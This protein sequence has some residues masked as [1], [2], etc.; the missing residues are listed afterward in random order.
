MRGA[1]FVQ[2]L[3]AGQ[4]PLTLPYR[5]VLLFAAGEVLAREKAADAQLKME[6]GKE[7]LRR[8]KV[9]QGAHK[10]RPFV[11][12]GG[13]DTRQQL[14]GPDRTGLY[15]AGIWLRSGTRH[16]LSMTELIIDDFKL[17]LDVRRSIL[18]AEPGSLQ[19]L[20]NCH[21]NPGGEIEKR[22]AIP[23]VTALPPGQTFG[24]IGTDGQLHV[25]GFAAPMAI[26]PGASPFPI[27]YHQLEW[28]NRP[29]QRIV[30]I[31]VFQGQ[32]LVC[33]YNSD[34]T[35]S[36]WWNGVPVYDAVS[37]G[38]GSYV[39]VW[40]QKM[41]RVSGPY[42]AFAGIGNPAITDPDDT[43][44]AGAGF[45]DLTSIDSESD[46]LQGLELYYKQMAAF[47]RT[48][49]QIWNLDPDPASNSIDQVLRIGTVSPRSVKQFGTGD[50]LF[51]SDSGI[52]SLKAINASMAA[53]VNDVG[54]PID[55]LM[56]DLIRTQYGAVTQAVAEVAPMSGRYWLAIGNTIFVLSYFPAAKISAWS[57]YSLPFAPEFLTTCVNR[58][59]ARAGDELYMYG[60]A[61]GITYDNSLATVVT[62][63]MSADTPTTWKKPISIDLMCQGLW[64]LQAGMLANSPGARELVG[65]FDGQTYSLQSI[66]Y[67]GYG[68]HI[69]L[70]LTTTDP[71]PA[72]LGS[73]TVNFLKADVK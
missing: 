21:I 42:L 56:I 66:P 9:R 23:A 55:K 38:P 54:S 67:A 50:V 35:Y 45:I 4:R 25:F 64:T 65:T 19:T 51:L 69:G 5:P 59:V 3:L 47:A 62:P 11:I 46:N 68:T 63:M 41:Y 31:E 73:I 17:G 57:T 33:A 14:R 2:P 44:N 40:Q 70:T 58:V 52:R 60:G 1:K 6:K 13:G 22:A 15:P 20:D 43:N 36:N 10:R 28:D 32:F 34:G 12:G 71:S 37:P 24:L 8:M 16:Q 48:T 39:R 72:L 53:A 27:V 29:F 7:W 18:T 26:D 30:D 61:D 49:T